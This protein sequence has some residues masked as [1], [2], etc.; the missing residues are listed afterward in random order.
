[1]EFSPT[2]YDMID[3]ES[4]VFFWLI[5]IIII[6]RLLC[7]GYFGSKYSYNSADLHKYWR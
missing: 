7:L 3:N 1:M 2:T 4:Y 5:L 6:H